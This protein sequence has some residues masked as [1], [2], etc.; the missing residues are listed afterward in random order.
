VGE[1]TREQVAEKAGVPVDFVDRLVECDVITP[2]ATAAPFS[3]SDMR[4][5]RFVHGLEQG[6]VPLEAVDSAVRIGALSFAFFDASFWSRFGG[7]A[8][9]TYAELSAE[10]GLSLE[11]LQTVRE[12][13]GYAR[14][15]PEDR[16]REDELAVVPLMRT[17]VEMRVDP[18]VLERHVR[19]WGESLRRIAEADG[20]FYR[21]QVEAPLLRAGL[22]WSDTI[23]AASEATEAMVPWIDPA[24]LAV[25]HAQSEHTW[26]ANVVEAVESALEAEGLH[27]SVA[28]PPAMCFLDLTGYTRLTEERGDRA[29]AETAATLGALVQRRSHAH[30]G[31]PVKWLGDGVMVFFK[32]PSAVVSFALEARDD[33]GAASLPPAHVGIASGPVIFQDGDYFGRTVNLAARI[34]GHATAGQVLVTDEVVQLTRDPSIA[35]AEIGPV[36]L[37]GVSREVVLHEARLGEPKRPRPR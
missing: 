22:G 15:R 7:L 31:R 18:L 35:F 16:L 25:Y 13:M 9:T 24:L 33:V 28:R 37:K 5:A 19:I 23:R 26:M 12:S 1:F 4:R 32:D 3:S 34:A 27:R 14:P 29:A 17:L 2:D 20:D 6:G 8:T 30:G 11:L 21:S 10:S 36:S